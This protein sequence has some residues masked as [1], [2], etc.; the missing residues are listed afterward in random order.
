MLQST[1]DSVHRRGP[2]QR[3][4]VRDGFVRPQRAS[5]VAYAGAFFRAYLG[6]ETGLTAYLEGELEWPAG[7]DA[8][9]TTLTGER[10]GTVYRLMDTLKVRL[11]AV[12]VEE[13]KVDFVPAEV[14][15]AAPERQARP[16]PQNR[17]GQRGRRRGQ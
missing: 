16:G 4:H 1:D 2:G 5:L 11:V 15:G 10:L 6:G 14:D 13:R 3:R 8:S 12:N 9:G 7:V 17:K